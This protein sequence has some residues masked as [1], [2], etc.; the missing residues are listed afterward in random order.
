MDGSMK[1]PTKK[2]KPLKKNPNAKQL[3]R[4]VVQL[5]VEIGVLATDKDQAE[6]I[7]TKMLWDGLDA[8]ADDASEGV[9]G[10]LLSSGDNVLQ[11][12]WPE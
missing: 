11:E 8:D 6:E 1:K 7:A 5:S 2:K 10:L 9:L 4:Y 3:S 12:N